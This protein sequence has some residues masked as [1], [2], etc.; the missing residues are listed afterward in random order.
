MIVTHPLWLLFCII[1]FIIIGEYEALFYC[2]LGW[3]FINLIFGK[4]SYL[5]K[6]WQKIKWGKEIHKKNTLIYENTVKLLKKTIQLP[7]NNFYNCF[8]KYWITICIF[9]ISENLDQFLFGN[10]SEGIFPIYTLKRNL[11]KLNKYKI[12][13]I[14]KILVCYYISATKKNDLSSNFLKKHNINHKDFEKEIFSFFSFNSED[15]KTFR[16]LDNK[17]TNEPTVFPH[18]IFIKI[19]ER[20]LGIYDKYYPVDIREIITARNSLTA[21]WTIVFF[22]K[23]AVFNP[24]V[25]EHYGPD[26]H[27]KNIINIYKTTG[28]WPKIFIFG[29]PEEII[30]SFKEAVKE[31]YEY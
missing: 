26:D 14:I 18:T 16:N 6:M 27:T 1:L 8:I 5:V 10:K 11:N 7:K 17:Y 23:Y 4:N 28:V 24:A 21:L 30:E 15:I 22:K 29:T 9:S 31:N 25:I 2:I 19:L 12:N 3:L 20:A 13:E